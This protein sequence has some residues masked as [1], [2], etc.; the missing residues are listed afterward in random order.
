M[1]WDH[2]VFAWQ[3][4]FFACKL[5]PVRVFV[6]HPGVDWP[7]LPYL[8]SIIGNHTKVDFQYGSQVWISL[9]VKAILLQY[10]VSLWLEW[11]P[12]VGAALTGLLWLFLEPLPLGPGGT[13]LADKFIVPLLSN[14]PTVFGLFPFSHANPKPPKETSFAFPK[15]TNSSLTSGSLSLAPFSWLVPFFVER[16][17][18]MV[19][20]CLGGSAGF[21]KLSDANTTTFVIPEFDKAIPAMWAAAHEVGPPD[22]QLTSDRQPI[23]D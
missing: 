12:T 19:G 8:A 16:L 13:N 23:S 9:A 20:L 18:S 1:G 15:T 21:L 6:L 17:E 5:E 2:L 4:L 10:W 11:L 3:Q 22:L 7:Q 14:L